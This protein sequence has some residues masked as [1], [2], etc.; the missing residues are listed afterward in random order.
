VQSRIEAS[1]NNHLTYYFFRVNEKRCCKYIGW[2]VGTKTKKPK[3]F[4]LISGQHQ[5]HISYFMDMT[6]T[7]YIIH[8]GILSASGA[9]TEFSTS[10]TVHNNYYNNYNTAIVL[11]FVFYILSLRFYSF[12]TVVW[13]TPN[14][15]ICCSTGDA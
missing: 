12:N 15:R 6:Y 3:E 13:L 9:V 10:V 4:G 14:V 1:F 2:Y 7:Y 5:E 11:V 8:G